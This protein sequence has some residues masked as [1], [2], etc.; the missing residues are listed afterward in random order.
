MHAWRALGG[1]LSFATG[2]VAVSL[3]PGPTYMLV[4]VTAGTSPLAA[5]IVAHLRAAGHR[6]RL[7]DR[8][9]PAAGGGEAVTV[10]AL[11]AGADDP[12]T[13]ELMVGV[14]HV[15]HVEPALLPTATAVVSSASV[16]ALVPAFYSYSR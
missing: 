14:D 1:T 15:V 10:C 12:T 8:R 5:E 7:T 11:D 3:L 16:P 2:G 4:L 6:C 13:D 9:A